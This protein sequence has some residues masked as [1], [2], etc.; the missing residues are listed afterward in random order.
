MKIPTEEE[1]INEVQALKDFLINLYNKSNTIHLERRYVINQ[2]NKILRMLNQPVRR[3]DLD[4]S[5]KRTINDKR[6][7]TLRRGTKQ[8]VA[9]DR[10]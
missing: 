1:I 2:L 5:K 9:Q 10:N 4:F 3:V 7:I 6:M 8:K